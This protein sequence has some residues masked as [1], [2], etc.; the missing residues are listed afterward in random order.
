MG[1]FKILYGDIF[2]HLEGMEAIVNSTNKYMICG[3]GVCGQ[4]YKRAGKDKLE[5]YCHKHFEENMQVNEIRITPGF[6][7]GIDIINIYCPKAYES[8]EPL[9]E[10]LVGYANIFKVAAEKGYANIISVSLGT[11]VHGYRHHDIYK[12]VFSSL[13]EL[14]KRTTINFTMVLNVEVP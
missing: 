11:G 3:S 14:C 4:I 5:E 1:K 13:E 8:D 9:K 10:L 12:E 2:N 7:L 6:N